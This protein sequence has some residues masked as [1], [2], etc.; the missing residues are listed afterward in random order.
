MVD[1]EKDLNL[2]FEAADKADRN[3]AEVNDAISTLR[4]QVLKA[5]Q[6]K[7]EI[8]LSR[9]G[10]PVRLDVSRYFLPEPETYLVVGAVNP[11]V[12]KCKVEQLARWA[13]DRT[14]YP[15]KLTWGGNEF[16]ALDRKALEDVFACLLRDPLVAEQI[17]RLMK[18]EP[19]TPVGDAAQSPPP[20]A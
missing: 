7:V 16:S 5:T 8:S 11:L 13:Q 19:S 14:G 3:K 4:T 9:V 12:K 1:Y 15:C 6:G 18:M 20:G 10:P 2:G 17:R